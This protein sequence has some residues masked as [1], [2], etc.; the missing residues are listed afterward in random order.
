MLIKSLR[1]RGHPV[2]GDLDLDF[3]DEAG[4]PF[5]TIIFAGGNGCGKTVLLEVIH[6]IFEWHLRPGLGNFALELVLDATNLEQLGQIGRVNAENVTPYLRIEYEERDNNVRDWKFEF[7]NISDKPV[8]IYNYAI[9]ADAGKSV[10]RSFL[11]E[12]NVS[13]NSQGITSV[14]ALELDLPQQRSARSGADLAQQITQLLIDVRAADAEET[15]QWVEGHSGQAPPQ[16]VIA[17]R[18]RRF[19]DA[20]HFM[21]P[22][23]RLAGI[24]RQQNAIVVQFEEHGRVTNINQLS[25]GEKQIVFRGGFVLKN[26]S[27]VQ[28]GV[29]LVD[30]PELSLHPEWQSRILGFYRRLIP[31]SDKFATQ[32]FVATHSPFIVHG[33]A[34][35]KVVV[36]EKDNAGIIKVMPEP[37]YPSPGGNL[38]IVAFNIDSFIASAKYNLLVLVEGGTDESILETAWEKLHPGEGRFF[39][40]RNAMGSK[41]INITLNDMQLFAKVTKQKI[42]G[43]MDLD[44]AYNQWNGVW[45]KTSKN[46]ITDVEKGLLRKHSVGPGWAML[47]PVPPHR[48]GFASATIGGKSIL[49]IE[50]LFKD[51]DIPPAFIDTKE[52]PMGSSIKVFR[53]DRKREF[54]E[55]IKALPKAS[56][57][58]FEPIFS[59]WREIELGSL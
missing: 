11:T 52:G 50:F 38:G 6:R 15:V 40:M 55:R 16:E 7:R 27:R 47:L 45:R 46:I 23:K 5:P 14:T 4:V 22:T 21:F 37:T 28:S 41:N 8:G 26:L 1:L 43:L 29:L 58:A 39:E 36:L 31:H 32:L 59:R 33:G 34:G 20:F 42:V 18:M 19:T 54:A 2:L 12:A 49:S 30:E 53:D 56:F 10:L 25:T 35:A 24:T 3:T 17:K 44:E 57:A 13:F 48:A 9:V 51:K